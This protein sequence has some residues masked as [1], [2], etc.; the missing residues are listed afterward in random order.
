MT[1]NNSSEKESGEKNQP[2]LWK[3]GLSEDSAVYCHECTFCSVCSASWRY[4]RPAVAGEFYLARAHEAQRHIL[5]LLATLPPPQLY[6][7]PPL[8]M[9][10]QLFCWHFEFL[11]GFDFFGKET[12]PKSNLFSQGCHV[13]SS[14]SGLMS[15]EKNKNP[16]KRVFK[17]WTRCFL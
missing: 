14:I 6:T 3:N 9:R 2:V 15:G 13:C 11:L 10:E 1:L 12:E 4:S 8:M 17:V 5:L 16:K 7:L